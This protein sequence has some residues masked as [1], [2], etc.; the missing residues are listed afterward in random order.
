MPQGVLE[1]LPA[2]A[3]GIAC[4]C[5]ACAMSHSAL[6]KALEQMAEVLRRR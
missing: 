5:R 4:V 6:E 1:R 3:L 2:E